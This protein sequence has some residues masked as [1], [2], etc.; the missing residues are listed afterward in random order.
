MSGVAV[1]IEVMV[2]PWQAASRSCAGK[3]GQA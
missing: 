3:K 1:L 2:T